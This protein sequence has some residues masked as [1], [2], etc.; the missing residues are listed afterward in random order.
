MSDTEVDRM[1]QDAEVN[2]AADQERREGI[3]AKNQADALVYQSEKQL[4]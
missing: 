1:V 4:S 2:A 3:E